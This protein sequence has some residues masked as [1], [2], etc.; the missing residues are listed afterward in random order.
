MKHKLLLAATWLFLLVY[1]TIRGW[2]ASFT[3]GVE[4]R[5]RDS[6]SFEL[7]RVLPYFTDTELR[8]EDRLLRI[9]YLPLCGYKAIPPHPVQGRL[10][11]YEVE[12]GQTLH[13]CFVESK[14]TFAWGW[15][16]S[17]LAYQLT[18][19]LTLLG[20]LAGLWLLLLNWARLGLAQRFWYLAGIGSL[21]SLWL[22]WAWQKH[23]SLLEETYL[24]LGLWGI[25][26]TG[27]LPLRHRIGIQ[28][29]L[30]GL[31]PLFVVPP[32]VEQVFAEALL[33]LGILYL[34][35]PGALVYSG[36][37]TLWL[38]ARDPALVG[39][40]GGLLILSERHLWQNLRILS[41]AE[42][43]LPTLTI[44]TGLGV[45]GFLYAQGPGYTLAGGISTA[46]L[47][48]LV[49]QFL[50]RIIERSRYRFKLL[51]ERLPLLWEIVDKTQLQRFVLD[52][53]REY[54]GV[55]TIHIQPT[56]QPPMGRVV[57]L[58]R[59]GVPPPL[60][61]QDTAGEPDAIFSLPRYG[62]LLIKEGKKPLRAGDVEQLEPFM[63]GVSIA[64]RHLE[65]FEAAHEARLAALRGQL[66]PH[67]LFNALN[68][69]QALIY[70]N[71]ALAEELMAKLGALLRRTLHH[72]RHLKVY[73][74]EEIILVRDYLDIEQQRFGERLK[75]QWNLPSRL[76]QVEVPPFALQL[77]AENVVKH[78]VSRLTR[79]VSLRI[80]L[81]ETRSH[82]EISVEDDGPGIDLARMEKGIGLSNL[83]LRLKE[84]Y[85]GR[86]QLLAERLNP[87]TR[88]RIVLPRPP[89]SHDA[90]TE[91]PVVGPFAHD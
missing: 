73:L 17:V 47:S 29:P 79:P 43:L 15:P 54:A 27:G 42:V 24:I 9:D 76:P 3:D 68:T 48:W 23:A 80:H 67:F 21:L 58:R 20:F 78:A 85:E 26:L 55:A 90:H 74:E 70:E 25:W 51:Q 63:A 31:S 81:Q 2:E 66:S 36:I 41:L 64:L 91:N 34:P 82:V 10:Y 53:L 16:R 71:P 56:S 61:I 28:A 22:F 19:G 4:W 60:R 40:M 39:L 33:T 75:V 11:L 37:W 45:G 44:L 77:L 65:L 89:H 57:W 14:A 46:L 87:G 88:V 6:C 13:V 30:L 35:F 86:A 5:P 72:A 84:L 52:T 7:H 1:H 62:W 18:E 38:G 59:S 50:Q 69:L 83:L 12:R 49:G 8:E 32:I